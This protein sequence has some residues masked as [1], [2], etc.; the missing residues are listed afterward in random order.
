MRLSA[1]ASRSALARGGRSFFVYESAQDVC[2]RVLTSTRLSGRV[3]VAEIH[4]T[5]Q[6]G[7]DL[8]VLD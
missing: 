1:D 6:L 4:L 2:L 7:G 3:R 5:A 8:A